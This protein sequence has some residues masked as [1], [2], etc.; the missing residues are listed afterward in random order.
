MI[1]FAMWEN[2]LLNASANL[3]YEINIV[4]SA[5][6]ELGSPTREGKVFTTN[7]YPILMSFNFC[8][9]C[10]GNIVVPYLEKVI[11]LASRKRKY[12]IISSN[13]IPEMMYHL[14]PTRRPL[15]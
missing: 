5:M 4:Q 8:K 1:F 11:L 12:D 14:F 3:L 6:L 15:N 13:R 7:F 10:M 9:L 2:I